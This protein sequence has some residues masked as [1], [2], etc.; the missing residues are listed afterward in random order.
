MQ[1]RS[2]LTLSAM[3][4][5]IW[6]APAL[7]Y[8]GVELS[9]NN[10]DVTGAGPGTFTNTSGVYQQGGQGVASDMLIYNDGRG[11]ARAEADVAGNGLVP[12]VKNY[13]APNVGGTFGNGAGAYAGATVG[14]QYQ[15]AGQ[16]T[17][18]F[19]SH[20]TA[21][22]NEPGGTS[23]FLRVRAALVTDL[24]GFT[25][26]IAVLSEFGGNVQDSMVLELSSHELGASY[27]DAISFEAQPGQVFH[28]V[29]SMQTAAGVSPAYVDALNTFTGTL[30]A[31]TGSIVVIPEP[32]SAALMLAAVGCLS[33]RRRRR[34]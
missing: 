31:S 16:A 28:L 15:G 19:S 20:L 8:E 2:V 34:A 11:V 25:T 3:A 33:I 27:M 5:L 4:L 18:T 23:A 26:D 24:Q 29:L 14:Y 13:V 21:D 9:A 12:T 30:S 32:A 1:V 17:I 10:A 22:L 6:S 7:G